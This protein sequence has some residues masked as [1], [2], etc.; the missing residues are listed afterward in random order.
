YLFTPNF[1]SLT[2]LAILL[3]G[4]FV[5]VAQAN[6]AGVSVATGDCLCVS[7][8]GVNAR[9]QPGT[10]GTTVVAV[11]NTGTCF[12][13]YGGILTKDGYTWYE[14][15]TGSSRVWVAGNYLI[16]GTTA[17]CDA[18]ACSATQKALA[19]ELFHSTNIHA[20]RVHPSGVTDNAFAYNNLNDMCNGH[21]ASRSRYTCSECSS[22]GAPGGTTC[23]STNL[24]RYLVA[25]K[26]RGVVIVNELAGA[27][28]SCQSRHYSGLAVDLHNDAR[29]S[30]YLS[31]CTSMGGWG[32]DEGNHIHCQFYDGTHPNW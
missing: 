22:P 2:M 19:C 6:L 3:V 21:K 1:K 8:S 9:N 11:Y 18:G 27:C 13:F 28:H 32:Q 25:L 15:N 20:A 12:H 31:T 24:L 16:K 14:L 23:L 7:G 5:A 30:E 26:N 4:L 29:S 17:Q 10:T